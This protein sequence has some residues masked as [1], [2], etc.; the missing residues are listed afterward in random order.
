[1]HEMWEPHA[2]RTPDRLDK[3]H[4]P[5]GTEW[6]KP[7]IREALYAVVD[8]AAQDQIDFVVQSVGEINPFDLGDL[9]KEAHAKHKIDYH[10]RPEIRLLAQ[11]AGYIGVRPSKV[12]PPRL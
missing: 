8:T 5:P 1:V 3:T 4:G 12:D 2:I 9:I 10:V 7:G 11:G 6:F